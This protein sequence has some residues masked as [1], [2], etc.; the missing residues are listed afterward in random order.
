MAAASLMK[1]S[2]FSLNPRAPDVA[3]TSGYKAA[4]VSEQS[5]DLHSTAVDLQEQLADSLDVEAEDQHLLPAPLSEAENCDAAWDTE[6]LP[7]NWFSWKKLWRFTGPGFL[8]S[9]AYIVSFSL[10]HSLLPAC[11]FPSQGIHLPITGALSA[12]TWR[13][14][15]PMLVML[16]LNP[17]TH[18]VLQD[19]GNLEG[20]LQAGANTGY[21]LLWV[22]VWSTLMVC[23]ECHTAVQ[24]LLLTVHKL[25]A[26][27]P[28]AHKLALHA[29]KLIM[30]WHASMSLLFTII[31]LRPCC[32]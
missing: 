8:M 5:S 12:Y 3:E 15:L 26:H 23:K 4:G 21:I 19:P 29:P 22:L 20:D 13:A 30:S 17:C 2:S 18:G 31:S 11:I 28:T 27:K 14:Q 10:L 16:N 9:I 32:P 25:T 6:H 7:R 24:L 1:W